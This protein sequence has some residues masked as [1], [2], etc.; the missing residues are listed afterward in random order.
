MQYWLLK[1]EPFKYPWSQLVADGQ[2]FWNGVRNYQARNYMMEMAVGELCLFYHSNEGKAIVGVAKVVKTHY[3]DPTQT[4]D[5]KGDWVVVD[6][7]PAFE[8]KHQ[9][10]LDVLRKDPVLKDLNIFKQMRLSVVK[11]DPLHFDRI[12]LMGEHGVESVR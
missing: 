3:P 1:S 9:I 6:V 7:A 12:L 4:S 10:P 2:T 5:E 11:V 8:L